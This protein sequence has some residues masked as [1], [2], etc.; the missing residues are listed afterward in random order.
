MQGHLAVSSHKRLIGKIS[1]MQ[2]YKN[3]CKIEIFLAINR[4]SVSRRYSPAVTA[5]SMIMMQNQT[6]PV[7]RGQSANSSSAGEVTITPREE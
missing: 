2:R 4:F 3:Q 7:L 1:T 6:F 5:N